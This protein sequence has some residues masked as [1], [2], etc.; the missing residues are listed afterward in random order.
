M[1]SIFQLI[2]L[3][4]LSIVACMMESCSNKS[5]KIVLAYVTSHGTTLPD[6]DIVTHINY[7]FAHV[8]S[9]FSKL[10]INT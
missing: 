3:L 1:K 9:T 10:K 2:A 7:A 4:C 6:P 8:D 5:E